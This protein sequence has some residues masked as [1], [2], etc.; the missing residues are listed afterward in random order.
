MAIVIMLILLAVAKM[1]H[2]TF[3]HGLILLISIIPVMIGAFFDEL[4]E[5]KD[6]NTKR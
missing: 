5:S 2:T 1:M 3:S 4:Y 6:D